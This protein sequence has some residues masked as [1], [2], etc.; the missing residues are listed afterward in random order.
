M[1]FF[2]IGGRTSGQKLQPFLL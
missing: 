1:W 2:K